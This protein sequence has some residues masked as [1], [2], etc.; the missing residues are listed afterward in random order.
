MTGPDIAKV[1]EKAGVEPEYK[2]GKSGKKSLDRE[3]TF[4]KMLDAGET[5]ESIVDRHYQRL[6]NPPR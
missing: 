4:N 2:S 5:P 3:A 1:A 6:G